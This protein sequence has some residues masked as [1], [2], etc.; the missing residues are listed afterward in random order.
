MLRN[1]T[2]CLKTKKPVLV[3]PRLLLIFF[4]GKTHYSRQK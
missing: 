1:L 3:T 2:D 4:T